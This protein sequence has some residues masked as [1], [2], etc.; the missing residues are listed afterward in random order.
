MFNHMI[1]EYK[2]ERLF[3]FAQPFIEVAMNEIRL[4]GVEQAG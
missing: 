3:V 1:A 4:R 2:I